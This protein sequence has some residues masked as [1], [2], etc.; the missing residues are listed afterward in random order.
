MRLLQTIR[1]PLAFALL[2]ACIACD[3]HPTEPGGIVSVRIESPSVALLSGQT[4]QLRADALDRRGSVVPG[5]PFV[6]ASS[7]PLVAAVSDQGA[8]VGVD[9]GFAQVTAS[10]GPLSDT[11]T[12]VVSLVPVASVS[13]SPATDSLYLTDSLQLVAVTKDSIGGTLFDR[14]VAWTSS[15]TLVLSVSDSGLVV[16]R[17]LGNATV[18]ATSEGKT[19]DLA[20]AIAPI[21]VASITVPD[22][23]ELLVDSAVAVEA[24]ARDSSGR[25]IPSA[26]L[27]WQVGDT[28]VATIDSLGLLRGQSLGA[29]AVQVSSGRA[30]SRVPVWTRLP[31]QA[32][33]TASSTDSL[34]LQVGSGT[35]LVVP[36]SAL[37]DGSP[38]TITER[39]TTSEMGSDLLIESSSVGAQ[40]EVRFSL[41][42]PAIPA[43]SRLLALVGVE[44]AEDTLAYFA[45]VDSI[46]ATRDANGRLTLHARAR[47]RTMAA[48]S[49]DEGAALFRGSA[50]TTPGARTLVR[51]ELLPSEC[52]ASESD[53]VRLAGSL[54]SSIANPENKIALILVHGWQ[55]FDSYLWRGCDQ[56]E[57]FDPESEI[58][59]SLLASGGTSLRDSY[60]FW[61]FRYPTFQRV[62]QSAADLRREI[63]LRVDPTTPIAIVAHSMG[64]LVSGRYMLNEPPARVSRLITLGTPWRGSRLAEDDFESARAVLG[65]DGPCK[66]PTRDLATFLRLPPPSDGSRDLVPTSDLLTRVLSPQALASLSPRVSSIASSIRFGRL[67]YGSGILDWFLDGLE[68]V[69]AELEGDPEGDGVVSL[70]SGT[71]TGSPQRL[72]DFNHFR[73]RD[74]LPTGASIEPDRVPIARVIDELLDLVP[75]TIPVRNVRLVG[76]QILVGET[77]TLRAS[78]SDYLDRPVL[79]RRVAWGVDDESIATIDAESGVITGVSAG[80]VVVTATSEGVSGTATF[81]VVAGAPSIAF[82]TERVS[83]VAL[84]GGASPGSQEVGVTNA[85]TGTLT[86]LS[87]SPTLY[88]AGQPTG[89]LAAV[90]SASTAPTTIVLTPAVGTLPAGTYSATV[91]VSATGP[92]PTALMRE[93]PVNLVIQTRV[94]ARIQILPDSQTLGIRDTVRFE[95][96]AFDQADA[97]M[98]GVQLTLEV[99]NLTQGDPFDI[100]LLC[101][102]AY[103]SSQTALGRPIWIG[104]GPGLVGFR[105]R[106]ENGIRSPMAR[107]VV[108]GTPEPVIGVSSDTV[109]LVAPLQSTGST[110]DTLIVDNIGTGH[111]APLSLGTVEYSVGQPVGWLNAG[112]APQPFTATACFPLGWCRYNLVVT[113]SAVGLAA[114]TYSAA[115]PVL[116]GAVGVTNSPKT[117]VV[118][119]TVPVIRDVVAGATSTCALGAG[120]ATYCWGSILGN[121]MWT[122]PSLLEG[123]GA[124]DRLA[125]GRR[126]YCGV[127]LSGVAYCWGE[128][129]YGQLGDGSSEARP[130][131]TRVIGAPAFRTV[132]GGMA[133]HTCALTAGNIAYCWG[134]NNWGQLGD[135]STTNRQTPVQV[136]GG[137]SFT[138]LA[139]SNSHTCGLVSSGDAYC[140]GWNIVGAL[141]DGT[142]VTSLTPVR[143]AGGPFASIVAG[144]QHTCALTDT[145]LA[146][147]WGR[148]VD[149]AV[150][151]GAQD[152]HLSPVSVDGSLTFRFLSAGFNQTCG[153]TNTGA[154]YCWG[155]NIDGQL[156][157]GSTTNR[158]IPTAVSGSLRFLSLSSAESHTCGVSDDGAIWCWGSN[159]YRQLGDG[160]TTNRIVPTLVGIP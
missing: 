121:S 99:V 3:R 113:A 68:C 137:L 11:A 59:G 1:R 145:G 134:G 158:R 19:A 147:C 54:R 152:L 93:L 153:I 57:N 64:G 156:G 143:V 96:I 109:A 131:P 136:A 31:P 94:V 75:T 105:F 38:V 92:G 102:T 148:N 18:R 88:A 123:S 160:T 130:T 76:Y 45:R 83:F 5:G 48:A 16:A 23:L 25:A 112:I 129:A 69:R 124:Y 62:E 4:K 33:G 26:V 103:C 39:A 157:D 47:I 12:V 21:P 67:D 60:Q 154:A 146:Y 122:N 58:W 42:A 70:T 61:I 85:G 82:S 108:A 49:G 14:P 159:T 142:Q 111:L 63:E 73:L 115:V 24:V 90:V 91:R 101:G 126:H 150:G 100:A 133:N 127:D 140:W 97:P 37:P 50:L 132:F 117:I 128:N 40:L 34:K 32:V 46:V 72:T 135:G 114:G 52:P 44:G 9:T 144:E 28:S 6:W 29:T 87:L 7:N 15:N 10:I 78:L 71:A 139:V 106:N 56:I 13:L 141:G 89:W 2:S 66:S 155:W 27:A 84:S 20:F 118:T 104:N 30:Q 55:I 98:Q 107:V 22:G 35:E 125:Q 41:Q 151:S 149:G 119:L 79:G 120:G 36:P 17:S 51:L 53:A 116:S 65:G 8:V 81:A 80:A 74:T 43:S 86:G 95:G 110:I 138:S 77:G